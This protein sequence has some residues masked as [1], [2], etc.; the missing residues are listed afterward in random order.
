MHFVSQDKPSIEFV[1][2]VTGQKRWNIELRN[3]KQ[4]DA[5]LGRDVLNAF[6]RCFVHADRLTSMTSCIHASEKLHTRNAVAFERDLNSMVWFTIG[7]LRELAA[8]IQDLRAALA[9]RGRLD[10][11]SPPWLVLRGLEDRWERNPFYRKK[12]DVGAFHVDPEV[13]DTGLDE[14]I[15]DQKDV[16]LSC[17]DSRR[18]VDSQLA[19]GLVALHNGLGLDLEGY[20]Q[21]LQV[22]SDDHGDAA[23]AI[24][25]AFIE[26]AQAAGVPFGG[27]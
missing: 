12:R 17:G 14:L 26:A 4:L 1:E 21:F 15:K 20:R 10:S 11:N 16:T 25:E 9:K 3:F 27:G 5:A 22:V 13:I 8:A 6:S 24:Q 2:P 23:N 7:T 18:S 19:L